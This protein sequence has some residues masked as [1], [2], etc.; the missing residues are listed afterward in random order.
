MFIAEKTPLHLRGSIE[1]LVR[2]V[3]LVSALT[4]VVGMRLRQMTNL[5]TGEFITE[6]DILV[7]MVMDLVV[8]LLVCWDLVI[9]TM[10]RS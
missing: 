3:L 1:T 9:Q 2:S 8:K 4:S 6:V 10:L 5:S 7:V